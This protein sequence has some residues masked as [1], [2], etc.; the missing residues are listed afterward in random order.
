M[1]SAIKVRLGAVRCH[2]QGLQGT[3]QHAANSRTQSAALVD[4]LCSSMALLTNEEKAH[5]A[6]VLSTI[7]WA[8]GDDAAILSLLMSGTSSTLVNRRP[9]QDFRAI[10]DHITT[11]MWQQLL[12]KETLIVVYVSEVIMAAT[13]NNYY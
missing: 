9:Q 5:I 11:D 10:V 1:A 6:V 13:D 8:A 7:P 4:V 12:D 2:L 3:P